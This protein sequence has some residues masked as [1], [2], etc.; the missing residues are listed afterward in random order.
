[1]E[2]DG[3]GDVGDVDVGGVCGKDGSGDK[4]VSGKYC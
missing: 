1:M 4:N 2:E 3:R